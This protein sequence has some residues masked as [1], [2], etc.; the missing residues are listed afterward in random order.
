[1]RPA[2]Q[3]ALLEAARQEFAER[4]FGSASI[5][6][7]AARAGMSLSAMYHY[8]SG[9][10]ELLHALLDEGMDRYFASVAAELTAV[11]GEK[12]TPADRLGAVVAATTRFRAEHAT[13]SNIL[14]LEERSLEAD[15]LEHYSRRQAEAT[16]LFR[17]PIEAGIA[18]GD[19]HTPYPDEARRG[20]IAMCNAVAQWYRPDG[21]LTLDALVDR[22]VE[23][24][25][26]LVEY[27]PRR[28]FAARGR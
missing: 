26:T 19:F 20:V 17:D 16:R 15:R 21:A 25:L 18:S 11:G 14:L 9:K 22:H 3:T 24:A 6:N 28:S 12:A 5:R 10:Q 2:G 4:G 1:M 23:L 8:Y 7:I 13:R 27:R